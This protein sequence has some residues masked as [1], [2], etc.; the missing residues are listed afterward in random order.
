MRPGVWFVGHGRGPSSACEDIESMK[1]RARA[2]R[3]QHNQLIDPDVDNMTWFNGERAPMFNLL[4]PDRLAALDKEIANE[5]K[6]KQ[7]KLRVLVIDH[8][9]KAMIPL[10][11]Q[12][13]VRG[14]YAAIQ[15]MQA[16][17]ALAQ[18]YDCAIILIAHTEK[19]GK[20]IAGPQ[21]WADYAQAVYRVTATNDNMLM[22]NEKQ[23]AAPLKHVLFTRHNVV[24]GKT[25][26]GAPA[27]QPC[28]R[29]AAFVA[30]EDAPGDNNLF[31][32]IAT[33]MAPG[34]AMSL[35]QV[36]RLIGL[37]VG[38]NQHERLRKAVPLGEWKK[39]TVR[40]PH[41]AIKRDFD[42]GRELIYCVAIEDLEPPPESASNEGDTETHG[43]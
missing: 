21:E 27:V 20:N 4:D 16:L 8:R 2:W 34:Q 24:V 33:R 7:G 43:V 28:V 25:D 3:I 6:L 42:G 13:H 19:G 37:S 26:R 39:Q 29:F 41:T 10:R 22:E 31:L 11:G 23:R 15:V 5:Q 38:G 9:R 30:P 1:V 36:E 12:E 32:D 14:P 35:P 18:K 40:E 17:R